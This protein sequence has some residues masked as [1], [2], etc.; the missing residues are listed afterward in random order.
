MEKRLK[1]KKWSVYMSWTDK[2]FIEL[3][4][5]PSAHRKHPAD[6]KNDLNY[7]HFSL[8][9]RDLKAFREQVLARGGA[10]YIDSEIE[11]GLENTWAFWMHDPDGN[12]FE[13]MEYTK[14]SYQVVGR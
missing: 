12:K 14:D 2:T 6:S 13:I 8:E 11:L 1:G 3:F 4:Y 9:V 10:P 7:T 5:V